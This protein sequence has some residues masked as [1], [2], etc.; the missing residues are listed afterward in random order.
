MTDRLYYDQTYLRE[1]DAVVTQCNP[2]DEGWLIALNQS[3]FYPTSGG[4]PYD[5]GAISGDP[6]SDV[7]V[8][9][10]GEVWHRVSRRHDPGEKVHGV[11][12]WDRRFDHMQQ[13]A[14]EHMIANAI[15]RMYGGFTI[16]LHLGASV[17][18]IDVQM[19]DGSTRLDDGQIAC[20]E[21]DV[22]AHIQQNVPIRCWFPE[23]DELNG[24][25]LRKAPTVHEHV[26]IV[27][28]GDF[29]MVACGGTH[30]DSAGQIGLVKIVDTRPSKGKVRVSFVCGM[31][32]VRDYR[33]KHQAITE[34]G[35]LLS[36][37]ETSV[38]ASI[39]RMQSEMSALQ[40]EINVE[41]EKAL[42]AGTEELLEKA[43]AVG[44]HS[45]VLAAY[46]K[47]T[48][49][50]LRKLASALTERRH[51][52]A[53]LSLK[54]ENGCNVVFARSDDVDERMDVLLKGAVAACGGRGGGK[55]D[56]AQ[57]SAPNETALETALSILRKEN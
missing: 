57:G 19:P 17:S 22:N 35:A 4:Q 16:G 40:R 38:P 41:R 14:G 8:D 2:C 24:L 44:E 36:V 34:A 18:T 53:L 7:F 20:I 32:A 1:F 43:A 52:I 55:P 25:P 46:E 21:D 9:A 6:V 15:W 31:R 51:V 42:L 29:E 11:I 3:A 49:D 33:S 50:A 30:P 5:T 10:G 28:I 48:I 56:F 54:N 13:H 26:R 37:P 47:G 39:E 12:D 23:S 45:V 27:A